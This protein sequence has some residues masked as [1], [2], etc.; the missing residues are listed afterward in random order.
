[1]TR[2]A[3]WSGTPAEQDYVAAVA[4]LS[5][6]MDGPISR[7]VVDAL[8][9]APVV[10]HRANDL[11]RAGALPLLPQDDPEVAKDLKKV[12]QGERLSQVL[13]ARGLLHDNRPLTVADGYHRICASYHLDEDAPI[14]C[15]IA[16]LP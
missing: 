9:T 15:R 10:N 2:K 14:P 8:R 13:L 6:L 16:T 5:L 3:R 11:L 7:A 12:K 1:M 4:Y